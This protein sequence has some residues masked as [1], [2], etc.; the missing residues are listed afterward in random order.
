M[1]YYVPYSPFQQAPALSSPGSSLWKPAGGQNKVSTS[2]FSSTSR[3]K[4]QCGG[5]GEYH[6]KGY[7]F[8]T[9]S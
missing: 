7:F 8:S 4:E 2:A 5:G 1:I 6:S 9:W 3:H